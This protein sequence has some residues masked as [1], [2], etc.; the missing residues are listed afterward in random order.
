MQVKAHTPRAIWDFITILFSIFYF[1][2]FSTSAT[3]AIEPAPGGTSMEMA[4]QKLAM[5]NMQFTPSSFITAIKE[6]NLPA[7]KLFLEAGMTTDT[8]APQLERA[9]ILRTKL[10]NEGGVSYLHV[11]D[12][13]REN[14]ALEVAV[15][16]EKEDVVEVLVNAGANISTEALCAAVYWGRLACFKPMFRSKRIE[17]NQRAKYQE[18]WNSA[19]QQQ[20]VIAIAAIRSELPDCPKWL[21]GL[22]FDPM[23]M[24]FAAI[25]EHNFMAVERALDSYN[26]KDPATILPSAIASGRAALQSAKEPAKAD[27]QKIVELLEKT[28]ASLGIT[29][30]APAVPSTNQAALLPQNLPANTSE[31]GAKKVLRTSATMQQKDINSNSKVVKA[32]DAAVTAAIR[33]RWH[34]LIGERV[35]VSSAGKVKIEFRLNSEGTATDLQIVE[36]EVTEYLATLCQRAITDP[37]SPFPRWSDDMRKAL[38]NGS[39]HITFTFQYEDFA[40]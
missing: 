20:R 33:Q 5:L 37:P 10:V 21:L 4:R 9:A 8:T 32:Y 17:W 1:T 31:S 27:A 38:P 15:Y 34:G 39:R 25:D 3:G 35:R 11:K 29:A 22:G 18:Q 36:N 40:D 2:G 13:A 23:A 24:L 16:S 12:S 7:V 26:L 14:S 19:Q 6:G 30:S 28:G